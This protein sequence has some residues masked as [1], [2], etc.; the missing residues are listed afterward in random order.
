[1]DKYK[2]NVR[3]QRRAFAY[4]MTNFSA[5]V[6]NN[7]FITYYVEMAL[8]VSKVTEGWF[9]AAQIIYCGWNS[10]NDPACGWWADTRAVKGDKGTYMRRIPRIKK[11]GPLWAASF[12]MCW[13][14]WGVGTDTPVLAGLHLIITL[15]CYDGWLSVT[16]VNHQALLADMTSD[17]TER[18][19]CNM[20]GAACQIIGSGSIFLGHLF[21]NPSDLTSF[22]YFAIGSAAV[23]CIGFYIT[24]SSPYIDESAGNFEGSKQ[25]EAISIVTFARQTLKHKNLWSF[26][27]MGLLQQFACTFST[28][29]FSMF[30]TLLV[31]GFLPASVQSAVLYASFILPHL[32]TMAVTPILRIY[33]KKQVVMGLFVARLAVAT[34]GLY[35]TAMLLKVP[36]M[37]VLGLEEMTLKDDAVLLVKS[38]IG[39]H[40]S[41]AGAQLK[42]IGDIAGEVDK[43]TAWWFGMTLTFSVLLNRILTENVCRLEPL[44]VTDLIDEDCILH[45]RS[46]L[47]SSMIFGSI[48]LITK[49][50]QSLAPMVGYYYISRASDTMLHLFLCVLSLTFLVPLI[51]TTLEILTW[52]RY[53]L[54]GKYLQFIKTALVHDLTANIV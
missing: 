3:N 8:C 21:W 45:R 4:G 20:Y 30:L 46:H 17:N 49:P 18:E 27:A 41:T 23:S 34:V 2:E 26:A 13:F 54:T 14:P 32:G 50:A 47:M 10:L 31:G 36:V 7:V 19:R 1:M 42:A 52:S 5:A 53:G 43:T 28:N 35:A 24:C 6:L 25:T 39:E 33:S 15:I 12:L 44:L 22:R 48:A 29:F 40:A 9:M 38:V 16:L 51:C 11:A 37:G